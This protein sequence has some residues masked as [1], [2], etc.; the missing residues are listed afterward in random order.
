MWAH[1]PWIGRVFTSDAKPADFL[2]QYAEVFDTVEGNTTFYGVPKPSTIDKWGASIGPNF[3][4]CFK[5]PRTITHDAALEGASPAT[6]AFFDTIEPLRPRLG[7]TLIQLSPGFAP[8][9]L[10]RLRA[11]LDLWS[12]RGPFAVE[13]RHPEFFESGTARDDLVDML[14]ER[15]VDLAIFDSRPLRSDATPDDYVLAAQGRKPD[16]PVF[17]EATGPYPMV[18]YIAQ[19]EIEANSA[20][21]AHWARICAEWI[22]EGRRPYF[23]AHHPDDTFAPDIAALFHAA[24]SELIELPPLPIFPAHQNNRS[25]GEDGAQLA[26]FGATSNRPEIDRSDDLP[27]T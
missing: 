22:D 26:L 25:G 12:A 9:L 7:P 18:R 23:F 24:L 3:R 14:L 16:L 4:F 19:D 15:E 10:P 6:L 13:V 5:V 8:R 21:L 17:E 20:P 2:G 11:F 1:R 27:R